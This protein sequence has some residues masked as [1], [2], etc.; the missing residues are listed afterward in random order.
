VDDVLA[1]A[2]GIDG[3]V[4]VVGFRFG[5]S[6]AFALAAADDRIRA[7]V[8]FY[9][10]PPEEV[11]IARIACPVFGLYGD[12]D[13]RLMKSLPAVT[14]A[15]ADAGV[16]FTPEVWAGVGHAFFNDSNATTFDPDA[17]AEAWARTLA[18]LRTS[19]AHLPA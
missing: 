7:A 4:A 2:P 17:A 3:R 9:G 12:Q 19:L 5:G 16:T 10:H 11:A 1:A 15:M 18:F 6:Y 13:E 14:T 8:P